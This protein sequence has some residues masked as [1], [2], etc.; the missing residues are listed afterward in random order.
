VKQVAILWL[1]L[2]LP[3]FGAK[4]AA[5]FT[6]ALDVA[7]AE[8]FDIAVLF[9]GSEWCMP[10]R[11]LAEGWN[12]SD[13]AESVGENLV[14]VSIDTKEF[15]TE[16]E[17]DLAK[18]NESCP[19]GPSSYPAVML[20]DMEG[21]LVARRD[22]VEE[23]EQMGALSGAIQRAV[24]VRAKR[25]ELWKRA[26]S[27]GGEQAAAFYGE[28]LELMNL[29]LGPKR[30]YQPILEKLKLADPEGRSGWAA[31][32]EFPGMGLVGKST[33]LAGEKKFEEADAQISKWLKEGRLTRDQKQVAWSARFALYQRWPER[34]ERVPEVLKALQ[35]VDPKSDLGQAA[36]EYLTMLEKVD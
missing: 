6:E 29:G 1:S 8:G 9:H 7:K 27:A 18:R 30:V 28:G 31:R 12:A 20:F 16:S 3:I 13:F 17:Q 10:G 5:D 32:Y 22:G 2:L 11:P 14:L 25:D 19:V 4:R 34:K 15:P 26:E 23:I 35:K 24:E 33:Q 36:A 21:R